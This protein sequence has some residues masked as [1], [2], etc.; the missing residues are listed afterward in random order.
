MD[1]HMLAI[2]KIILLNL[3]SSANL[4]KIKTTISTIR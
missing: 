1:Q 2:E 3:Q 4:D